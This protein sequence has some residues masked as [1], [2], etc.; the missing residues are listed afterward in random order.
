MNVLVL[1]DTR[2]LESKTFHITEQAKAFLPAGT[3]FRRAPI[4][5]SVK[6]TRIGGQLIIISHKWSGAIANF[7]RDD[8]LL[9]LVTTLT[10]ECAHQT[11][12]IIGSYWPCKSDAVVDDSFF[13]GH[14]MA[15]SFALAKL[16]H[17]KETRHTFRVCPICHHEKDI[18]ACL[19]TW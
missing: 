16:F 10:L 5:S 6:G 9:A 11:L 2:L 12:M 19:T 4:S 13:S 3:Q 1:T 14:T 7:S 15:E 8:S 18:S 17:S